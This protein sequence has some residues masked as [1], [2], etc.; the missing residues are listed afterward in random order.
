MVA[1]KEIAVA[2]RWWGAVWGGALLVLLAG[3]GEDK[4]GDKLAADTVRL[5]ANGVAHNGLEVVDFV[6]ENGWADQQMPNRYTVKYTFNLK[7]VK[8]YAEV[9]LANARLLRDDIAGKDK[10]AGNG[11]FDLNRL[12]GG[13]EA[14]QQSLV[15]NQWVNNQGDAFKPRY[16]QLIKGCA[17]CDAYLYE[18]NL[19]QAEQNLRFQTYLSSW[20]YFEEL[21]IKDDAVRGTKVARWASSAF[22]KTEKG[23]MAVQ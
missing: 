22:M 1:V 13:V 20:M 6:R 12:Q 5:V 11:L 10:A 17:P 23:W 3:C 4:P 18:P 14:M 7:L 16:Q 9:V 8:P 21:G 19:A 2:K 15:V